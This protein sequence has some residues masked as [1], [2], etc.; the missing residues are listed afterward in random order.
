MKTSQNH[1]APIYKRNGKKCYLDPIRHKLIYITPEET[2]RQKIISYLI[3]TLSVP[4]DTISVEE[5]LSHYG[6]ATKKR[7]DI[8]IHEIDDENNFRPIC[9][10][11]CKAEDVYLDDN[12]SKQA[13]TYC[14]L[15]EADYAMIT[16]GIDEIC[17][18]YDEI[19]KKYITIDTLPTYTEMIH[20]KY[21]ELEEFELP[22]RIPFNEIEDF[23][24]KEFSECG[25]NFFNYDISPKTP[26][27]LA[28]PAFNFLEGLL[29]TRVK[30]PTGNYG[31]FELLEDYGVR[32]VTYGNGSGGKFYGPYRSFLVKVNGSTEFFSIT[33]TTYWKKESP[34]NVKTCICVA[35]DDEKTAHHALQLVVDD[36][37]SNV[38]NIV[39]FYHHG[40][41][42]IGRSGSGKIEELRNF[43]SERYPQILDG[44]K[45]N[46]GQIANDR[47]WKLNDE[48]VIKVI[49]NMISYA[50]IRDEYRQHHKF[51]HK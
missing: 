41:I 23:L 48:A 2:V 51:K 12:T 8:V 4:K 21:T 13:L 19:S 11:E 22:E 40:K 42:A 7:A 39:T 47:L 24:K 16:N 20:G 38:D 17:Y 37:L 32:M 1:Y 3:D 35:H 26:I 33:V 49:S 50:I 18:K 5:H 44:N 27:N 46:L 45:F 9:V 36:N 6:I 43:V 25:N 31:L 29:D 30:M 10:I 34:E 28:V 15:I 14:D